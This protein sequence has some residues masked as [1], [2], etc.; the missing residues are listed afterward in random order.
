MSDENKDT[1]SE[2]TF[3]SMPQAF[4][5]WVQELGWKREELTGIEL[6]NEILRDFE[7]EKNLD[8]GW[9]K[10]KHGKHI[11]V[12]IERGTQEKYAARFVR[13]DDKSWQN[14]TDEDAVFGVWPKA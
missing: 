13:L 10:W 1:I 8:D 4:K 9:Q 5:D 2:E 3:N 11:D 6:V 12:A 7:A 14:K